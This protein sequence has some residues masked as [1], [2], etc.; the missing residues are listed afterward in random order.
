MKF[1]WDPKKAEANLRKHGISFDEAKGVFRDPM[2]L[3]FADPDHSL[4]ERRFL[5]LGTSVQNQLLI[6]SYTERKSATRMISAR[7]ATRRERRTYEEENI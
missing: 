2:L 4:E 5:I 6:V 7:K 1:E 3:I